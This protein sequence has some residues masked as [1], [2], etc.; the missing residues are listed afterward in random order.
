VRDP[1]STVHSYEILS[2]MV[3]CACYLPCLMA[4][5]ARPN[6]GK[7]PVILERWARRL[8]SAVRGRP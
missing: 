6:E 1:A 8:P 4:V 2:R 5:L 3:I 7:L